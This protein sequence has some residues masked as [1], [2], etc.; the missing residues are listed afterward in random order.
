MARKSLVSM[1]EEQLEENLPGPVVD[2]DVEVSA[3]G[4]RVFF[5]NQNAKETIIVNRGGAG[6]SKSYSLGQLLLLEKFFNEKQ[7]KIL[8]LRKTLPSLRISTLT[9]MNELANSYSL[10]DRIVEEKVHLNW[11][12]NGALIHFQ[13]ID[14]VEKVKCF[15]PDTDVLTK[16]GWKNIK[17]VKVGGLIATMNPATR[18]V[19]YK[20]VTKTFVYDYKGDLLS[21]ASDTEDRDAWSGFAVTPNHKMLI[22]TAGKRLRGKTEL[23]FCEAQDLPKSACSP[24]SAIWERG[25]EVDVCSIPKR[26]CTDHTS[27]GITNQRTYSKSTKWKSLRNGKKET[28]FPVDSWMKFLGWYISEGCCSGDLTVRISQTKLEGRKKLKVVLEEL[29]YGYGEDERGYSV[30]GKDLVSY[31]RQFGHSH[32]KFIPRE[33]LDL[34]PRHL[35]HLFEALI[36]G[37]GSR[38]NE[39]N[40]NYCTNSRQLADD[41]S[42]MG[43]K[44]GWV[45]LIREIDTQK[46][47][48]GAK[49]AWVVGFVKRDFLGIGRNIQKVPYEGK[50]YCLE[51]QPF[52]TMLTR[53]NGRVIWTGNSSDWNYIWLEEATE[54]TWD[55]YQTIKLRLRAK[56]LDG[57][58]NQMFLSFN[59][60]DERHWIKEK[61]VDD[62]S[63]NVKEIVSTYRD[64]PFLPEEY[65]KDLE[66]LQNQDMSFY[67]VYTLGQW[68]KLENIIYKNWDIISWLPDYTAVDKTF[69]GLDFGY[70]DPTALVECRVKGK[71]VWEKELLYHTKLTNADLINRLYTLIPE[72]KRAK[73]YIY[74][75]SAEPD[76]IKEIK[77]AGFRIK[78]AI[79]LVSNGID[80]VKRYVTHLHEDSINLI[81][82]KK[83]Y[84]WK[85]DRNGNVTD[86]PIGIWDH[87]MSAER[88]AI[89]TGLKGAGS[90]R[91]RY[92]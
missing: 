69:Y 32:E 89:H 21:P 71:D 19:C 62:P 73:Y 22:T 91:I 41:V 31:L 59:P 64:N 77:D 90:I 52:H 58:P 44:L 85:K 66:D 38:T 55:E 3:V 82:E 46:Y 76:R 63:Q 28:D 54:F 34:H 70:N 24:Q 51:V 10:K 11:Y 1:A 27:T 56:S 74:A 5:E 12:Y 83:A 37:D 33:I 81:K 30:Y 6:S 75:D 88:Y 92:I 84:S 40:C 35:E 86:E 49:P 48:V 20:P 60:I 57:K 47:Y 53:Y 43:L 72:E 8:I 67:N 14:D 17:D 9:L 7:K 42:E 23:Y 4:T 36:D 26:D 65:I 61:L 25:N 15:H 80:I 68:G 79:K 45:P 13:G 2:Q 87:L 39:S 18:K 16:T 50:V 29:G 78:P